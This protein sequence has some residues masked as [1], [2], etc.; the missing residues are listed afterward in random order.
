MSVEEQ[1]VLL[2]QNR[3]VFSSMQVVNCP[4]KGSIPPHHRGVS[5][6]TLD[7]SGSSYR[8]G[9]VEIEISKKCLEMVMKQEEENNN[10]DCDD[11]GRELP[12][13]F[14]DVKTAPFEDVL[15]RYLSGYPDEVDVDPDDLS[16][17]DEVMVGDIQSSEQDPLEAENPDD[18]DIQDR[19]LT[20]FCRWI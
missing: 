2:S 6:A 4:A 8:L 20:H 18:G 3:P 5:V 13:D 10:N 14:A 1:I 7:P 9:S 11:E 15:V 16:D 19:N 12:V 17:L